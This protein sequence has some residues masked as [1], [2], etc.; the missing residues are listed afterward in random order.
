MRG[1]IADP[2]EI[3]HDRKEVRKLPG[4]HLEA[5]V[6]VDVPQLDHVEVAARYPNAPAAGGLLEQVGTQ[7]Q[8][9]GWRELQRLDVLGVG[10]PLRIAQEAAEGL[11]ERGR[12]TAGLLQEQPHT[13]GVPL[14]RVQQQLADEAVAR[15]DVVSVH[16]SAP[17]LGG[18]TVELASPVGYRRGSHLGE[19][20]K[21]ALDIGRACRQLATGGGHDE[22]FVEMTQG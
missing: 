6:A 19:P 11:Q 10:A 21:T 22:P 12:C 2:E 16:A 13:G 14:S 20:G 8:R 7:V 4:D 15:R 5:E 1:V 18:S 3:H 9:A 17:D